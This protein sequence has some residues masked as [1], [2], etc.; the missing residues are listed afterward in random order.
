MQWMHSFRA[1]ANTMGHPGGSTTRAVWNTLWKLQ[2]P[3]KVHIFCWRALQGVI[4]LRA[5]LTNMHIGFNGACPIC[6][7]GPEDIRHLMFLCSNA[8]HLWTKL[9]ITNIIDQA[10]QVD[11]SGSAILEFILSL[12]DQQLEM[13]PIIN[14]KQ[15]IAVGGWYLWWI[16][17]K[18]THNES[19]PPPWRW[20]LSVLSIS[21]NNQ[22]ATSLV[23]NSPEAKWCK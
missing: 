2:I 7:Q 13:H 1:H 23:R 15:V 11:R 17:R 9:G 19:I 12:P 8:R 20:A 22:G 18:V 4:P 3:R 5:I 21:S 16:C 10:I 6:H 14:F